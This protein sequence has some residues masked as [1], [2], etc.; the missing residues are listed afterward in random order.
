MLNCYI[1]PVRE[2]GHFNQQ[3]TIL[4]YSIR[5]EEIYL[6]RDLNLLY[7]PLILS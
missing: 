2:P 1:K 7:G 6:R 5:K 3:T 4:S